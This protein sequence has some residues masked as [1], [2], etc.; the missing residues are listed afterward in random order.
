EILVLV[1]LNELAV[2]EA[3]EM[4]GLPLNTAYT[5][6]R[7]AKLELAAAVRRLTLKGQP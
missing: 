2:T 6:L 3:A 1:V 7:R 4:L 5:R